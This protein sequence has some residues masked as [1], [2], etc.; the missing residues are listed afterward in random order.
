MIRIL[1]CLVLL[2]A[3]AFAD[4]LKGE[5]LR[6]SG[7]YAEARTLLEATVRK[8]PKNLRARLELGRVYR[9]TGQVALEKAIWNGFYDDFESGALDKKSARDLTYV[10]LAARYLGGWKD[11]ND[12]FRDAVDADPKGKD[13]ARANLEWAELFLEKYDAGHAE[14]S[15]DEALKILPD[16]PDARALLARVKLEQGDTAGAEKQI[17]L[18]LKKQPKHGGAF[19]LRAEIAIHDERFDDAL[20]ACTAAL[21]LNPEDVRARTLAATVHLLRDDQKRFAAERDR[22]LGTNPRES[23]FFHGVAELFVIHHRYEEANALEQKALETN[24]KDWVAMAAQASNLLRLGDERGVELLKKAWDGDPYNVRTYNLLQLFE[25]VIPKGYTIL[26]GTPFRLRVATKEKAI[27]AR[28]I[29]P[30]ITREHGE[31][32]KRYGF[33]PKGPLTIELFT[34]PQHY[35]VRT[36]GLPGLEALGVTFGQVVTAMSPSL[37]KFNWGQTLWHEVAHIFSIQLSK[38]RVPRWFTE[39]LAEYETA[40]HRPE[41]SRH[42]HAELYRALA[43]GKLLSVAELNTGFT[44]AR[45]VAH[46]VV[47]YHQSA[48]TVMFLIRRWGFDKAVAALKLFAQGKDT[49]EVIPAVTGLSVPQ[50]DAAFRAELTQLLKPYA[51]TFF[52]RHSDYSDVDG[53]KEK[54]KSN[55]KD[56]RSLGLYAIALLKARHAD[57]A[58]KIINQANAVTDATVDEK[59]L[60]ILAA[61]Q[62]AIEL[63]EWS[64]A[65]G[66]FSALTRDGADGYD[67]RFGLGQIA[68]V[69]KNEAEAEKQFNLAKKLDPHKAEPYIELG[70]LW[71]KTRE[72]DAL[73]EIEQA[74]MLEAMDPSLPK[75][76]VEKHAARQRWAKVVDVAQ[77]AI[78]VAPFDPQV[79]AHYARALLAL[80][81]KKEARA[82]IAA[83]LECDPPDALKVELEAMKAKL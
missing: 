76:L 62:L 75:L 53:L 25:E 24:P 8:E 78:Y 56:L 45:D 65:K 54:I 14:V 63:K 29:V 71:L 44:R 39:G 55:P 41:W 59:R 34:D 26:E 66:F 82:E 27:L 77:L 81:M 70:K 43:D 80:G 58:Q 83:G 72:D 60:V 52:V 15:I 73:R 18:A 57:E 17:S 10:A 42:T 51:G 37:G 21:A 79:H 50:F 67:A 19:D 9:L 11:A 30:M 6:K 12:T 47:T 38:S 13:G 7:R 4:A 69:E 3:P 35:A 16:D 49:R 46:M 20:A 23:R 1:A 36:V 22:V 48:E 74:A 31:L 64:M 28:Y 33:S 32:V 61:G 40:R 68:V 2:A 5:A